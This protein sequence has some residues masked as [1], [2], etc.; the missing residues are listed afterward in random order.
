MLVEE[1][2]FGSREALKSE[3]NHIS[4]IFPRNQLYADLSNL[5]Q[6]IDSY[7]TMNNQ[8]SDSGSTTKGKSFS[9]ISKHLA[10]IKKELHHLNDDEKVQIKSSIH[11][12]FGNF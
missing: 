11:R 9:I 10:E 3:L 4:N 5:M 12:L 1:D 2:S 7:Y 8:Q 6:Q